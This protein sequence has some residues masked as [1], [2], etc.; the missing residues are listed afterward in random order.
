MESATFN[1]FLDVAVCVPLWTNA[2]RKGI[3]PS[4]D[5][6]GRLG[7]L[8]F[9]RQL[10]LKKENLWIQLYVTSY[11]WWRGWINTHTR[12][13][14]YESKYGSKSDSMTIAKKHNL[15]RWIYY[16]VK[17]TLNV[18]VSVTIIRTWI[19]EEF[20][21]IAMDAC[22]DNRSKGKIYNEKMQTCTWRS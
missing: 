20:I 2:L 9:V 14:I 12:P 18:S 13:Y 22:W 15:Y 8:A 19:S 5:R 11:S 3:N 16:D 1:Q 10:I 7:S 6:R 4:F 17:S 21:H